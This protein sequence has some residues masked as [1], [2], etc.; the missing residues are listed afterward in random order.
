M[1][2]FVVEVLFFFFYFFVDKEIYDEDFDDDEVVV[3]FMVVF[4]YFGK[5]LFFVF[6]VG[7]G[8]KVIIDGSEDSVL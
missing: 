7:Y 2:I 1:L 8:G 6:D 4:C 5:Q 3:Q